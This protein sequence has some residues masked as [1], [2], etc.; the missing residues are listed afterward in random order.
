LLNV[1]YHAK[2][3]A[4]QVALSVDGQNICIQVK[5]NGIGFNV[6]QMDGLYRRPKGY[7]L[8]T[9]K[10]RMNYLGGE[11]NIESESL[12]GS[13]ITLVSPMTYSIK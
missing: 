1:V 3:D 8:F 11:L 2:S 9:I 13:T 12:N 5:D 7:G 6:D 4:V 10:E